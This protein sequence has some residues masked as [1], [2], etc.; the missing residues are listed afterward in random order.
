MKG[1]NEMRAIRGRVRL[2]RRWLVGAF[3]RKW[4]SLALYARQ[5]GDMGA[6][7]WAGSPY[8]FASVR[9]RAALGFVDKSLLERD[10]AL[11]TTPP[12]PG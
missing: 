7:T 3:E 11:F 9:E 12:G 10:H 8:S 4:H 5:G 6:T 1:L 2:L